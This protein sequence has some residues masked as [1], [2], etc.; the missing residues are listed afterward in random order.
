ML[1]PKEEPT[2]SA[3]SSSWAFGDAT[4][5][6]ESA[7][8]EQKNS[9]LNTSGL[10]EPLSISRSGIPSES[11]VTPPN[12]IP[13]ASDSSTASESTQGLTRVG[14]SSSSILSYGQQTGQPTGSP[15]LSASNMPSTGGTLGTVP[16]LSNEQVQM[17]TSSG[18]LQ[19]GYI[20]TAPG[21]Y[22]QQLQQLLQQQQH[23]QIQPQQQQ[24]QHGQ[25]P[26]LVID[27][28]DGQ[29]QFAAA[30]NT[31]STAH[32]G[33]ML[34]NDQLIANHHAQMKLSV[35]QI[36][37]GA[38]A[39]IQTAPAPASHGADAIGR[40]TQLN[41]NSLSPD[42]THSQPPPASAMN[43]MLNM[44]NYNQLGNNPYARMYNPTMGLIQQSNLVGSCGG[45]SGST[46]GAPDAATAQMMAAQQAAMSA[47]GMGGM[48]I[49]HLMQASASTSA[50]TGAPRQS[51]ARRQKKPRTANSTRKCWM[52][53]VYG[54]TEKEKARIQMRYHPSLGK[55]VWADGHGDNFCPSL[56]GR[57][58][59]EQSIRA[60]KAWSQARSKRSQYH[61][62]LAK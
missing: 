27:N 56:N 36:S 40:P 19:L 50:T 35:G 60:K 24:Q 45:T 30:R 7:S 38:F 44:M 48:N 6:N 52:C 54:K 49:P 61:K 14:E 13:W 4:S 53:A 33:G 10:K 62:Y 23:Y 51:V 57:A 3:P 16:A 18:M 15:Q 8:R 41:G 59:Q 34:T 55:M 20:P 25:H 46:M 17:L 22:P 47:Y 58:T 43:L 1:S 2:S 31:S 28:T 9:Q 12:H 39:G 32:I 11:T 5:A 21:L 26:P 37:G 29:S 42:L